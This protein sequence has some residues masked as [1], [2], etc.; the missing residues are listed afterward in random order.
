MGFDK[1]ASA[2]NLSKEQYQQY[3]ADVVPAGLFPSYPSANVAPQLYAYPA[4]KTD[5]EQTQDTNKMHV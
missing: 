4:R 1:E 2:F 3:V 5:T